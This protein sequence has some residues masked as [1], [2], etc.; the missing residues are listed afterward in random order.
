MAFW[1]EGYQANSV[2]ALSERLGITRSSFYNAFESREAMFM[3]AFERYLERSPDRALATVPLE[4]SVRALITETFKTICENLTLDPDAKGCLAV[5][6]VGALCNVDAEIG[7]KVAAHMI[8]RL[9]RIK[10]LLKAA[11]VRGELPPGADITE[12]ALA[13]KTFLVGLNSMAKV[14]P[15]RSTL[16]PAARAT[17]AAFDLLCEDAELENSSPV[18]LNEQTTVK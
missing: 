13:L 11:V 9:E 7:P 5:N 16:W 12:T 10:A 4:G 17:L 3:E 8:V 18:S 6:S 2:K 15:N 1:R 14:L